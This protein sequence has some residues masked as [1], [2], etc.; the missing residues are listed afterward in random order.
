MCG[1]LIKIFEMV[2][3]DQDELNRKD[4]INQIIFYL[5]W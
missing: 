5:L 3:R 1:E 2:L 4:E